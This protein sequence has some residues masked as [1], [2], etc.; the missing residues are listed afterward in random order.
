MAPNRVSI[1][2]L[3]QLAPELQQWRDEG[4]ISA[5]SYDRL[6][7][8]YQLHSRLGEENTKQTQTAILTILGLASLLFGLAVLLF[9]CF[10]W[11][12]MTSPMKLATLFGSLAIAHGIALIFREKKLPNLSEVT[13]LFASI[14]FGVSI[15]QIAQIY[16][17][18]THFPEGMFLWGLGT[19]GVAMFLRTPLLHVLAGVLFAIWCGWEIIGYE[20]AYIIS[21]GT[22]FGTDISIP[23][24][25]GA[26]SLPI[27]AGLGLVWS[28]RRDSVVGVAIY[29]ALLLWWLSLWCDILSLRWAGAWYILVLGLLYLT[30][31]DF[32]ES[33]FRRVWLFLGVALTAGA[34]IPITHRSFLTDTGYFYYSGKTSFM[35]WSNFLVLLVLMIGFFAAAYLSARRHVISFFEKRHHTEGKF[36]T[37]FYLVCGIGAVFAL[38]QFCFPG[39]PL[40][41][42]RFFSES[43]NFSDVGDL[44]IF[45]AIISMNV[46]VIIL[47]W[48]GIISGVAKHR[49]DLYWCGVL[50][51]LLWTTLRYFDLFGFSGG[52]SMLFAAGFFALCGFALTG[53]VVYWHVYCANK[54]IQ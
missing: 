11:K 37:Q 2:F 19:F 8:K 54:N 29:A 9:V 33:K 18:K 31:S 46:A 51:F 41:N 40:T 23:V 32:Q 36:P 12:Y 26:Y 49:I 5:E 22:W 28:Y 20:T 17:T 24:Q 25:H 3:R 15:W 42:N 30:I 50:Y 34:L 4:I 47:A 43:F 52:N 10:N 6:V 14:L 7:E 16:H 21:L 39:V 48:H 53:T 27:F 45:G 13:F 38:L 35:F 44:P 1:T